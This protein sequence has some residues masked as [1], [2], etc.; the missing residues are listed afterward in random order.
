MPQ[1]DAMQGKGRKRN[2]L[3]WKLQ[4]SG[5]PLFL[6]LLIT[7]FEILKMI[8]LDYI[9]CSDPAE[10]T[11]LCCSVVQHLELVA[12]MMSSDAQGDAEQRH[13]YN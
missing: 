13:K 2:S 8:I 12:I 3:K 7:P 1:H 11:Q 4:H 6:E 9:F 10:R 5:N